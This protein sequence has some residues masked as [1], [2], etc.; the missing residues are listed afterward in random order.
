MIQVGV[1]SLTL[2]LFFF[3]G[4][5]FMCMSALSVHMKRSILRN[6]MIQLHIYLFDSGLCP[7]AAER[8]GRFPLA[9]QSTYMQIQHLGP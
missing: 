9:A 8:N 2:M 3:V 7:F 4:S 1:T 5:L 6:G